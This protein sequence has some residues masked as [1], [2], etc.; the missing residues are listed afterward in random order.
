VSVDYVVL[1][2]ETTGLNRFRPDQAVEIAVVGSNGETLFDS[3]VR[4]TIGMDAGAARVHGITD[5]MLASA[6][7][8]ADVA[9]ELTAVLQGK[10]IFI[11][12][13]GYDVPILD[14]TASAAGVVLPPLSA[15]CLM[16]AYAEF[17]GRVHHYYGTFVW[18]KLTRAVVQQGIDCSD[19]TAHRALGDAVMTWRLLGRM[20]ERGFDI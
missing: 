10:E 11:Y 17:W 18:Q 4:P 14:N 6:P 8:F 1:D 13:A 20:R 19:L 9:E 16:L 3:L 7:S 12:N 15:T 5:E 2:T